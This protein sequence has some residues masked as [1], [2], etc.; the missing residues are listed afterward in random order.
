[1]GNV[2]NK[3]INQVAVSS[4]KQKEHRGM[5]RGCVELVV[6]ENVRVAFEFECPCASV[7]RRWASPE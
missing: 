5:E 2:S 1:M 6:M 4:M 7:G 3:Q